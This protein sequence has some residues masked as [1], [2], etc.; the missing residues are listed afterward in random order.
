MEM[1]QQ[2]ENRN[3]MPEKDSEGA[4]LKTERAL[5]AEGT[6]VI[7]D[8]V[9]AS[10]A[11][12]AA[13]GVKGVE[14]LGKSSVAG[15]V[16]KLIKSTEDSLRKGVNVEVGKKEAIINIQMGVLHGYYIPDIVDEVRRKVVLEL[17][18]S[19]GLIAKEINIRIVS[20]KFADIKKK[21]V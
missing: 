10:I 2:D 5:I 7:E 16:T 9:V 17:M 3:Q 12:F 19:T 18:E 11:G 4:G 1:E 14:G 21:S 20:I 15:S 13:S 6:T 8:E